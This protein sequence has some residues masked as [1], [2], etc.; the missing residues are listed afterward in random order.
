MKGYAIPAGSMGRTI[1]DPV[2]D[3]RSLKAQSADDGC[4]RYAPAKINFPE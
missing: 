1:P 3:I 2:M 4:F